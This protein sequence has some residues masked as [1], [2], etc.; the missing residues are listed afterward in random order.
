MLFGKREIY[1]VDF[2]GQEQP[3]FYDPMAVRR[4]LLT[5]TSGRCWQLFSDARAMELTLLET[6]GDSEQDTAIRA[7]LSMR[8]AHLEGELA[9]AGYH[10]FGL[11]PIDSQTKEGITETQVLQIVKEF[12]GWIEEKKGSAGSC[13]TL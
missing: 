13:P 9:D 11:D 8:L 12:L 10:A 3:V 6:T 5:Q 1:Q 2:D 7:E 4:H